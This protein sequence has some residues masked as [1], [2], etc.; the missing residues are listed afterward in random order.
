M[1][2][3][4]VVF[5]LITLLP[6]LCYAFSPENPTDRKVLVLLDDFAIKSSHSLFFKSLQS[7]GFHLDFKLADDPK[8]ALQRYGRYFYDALILF[9]PTIERKPSFISFSEVLVLELLYFNVLHL[10]IVDIMSTGVSIVWN[11]INFQF[12][13]IDVARI[14]RNGLHWHCVI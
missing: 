2:K 5:T 10:E 11:F 14:T 3:S 12:L 6:F 13:C 4:V 7:R 9:A 8:I 1:S